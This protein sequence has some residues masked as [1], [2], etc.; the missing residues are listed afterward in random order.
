MTV[1]AHAGHRDTHRLRSPRL[2]A[3]RF[4]TRFQTACFESLL[5]GIL[6]LLTAG[7]A[8][9]GN[10][11]DKISAR[12]VV[13][14]ANEHAE[15]T[16]ELLFGD[17]KEKKKAST[18]RP[19]GRRELAGGGGG[20]MAA[21]AD[22]EPVRGVAA[23]ELLERIEDGINSGSWIPFRDRRSAGR[24]ILAEYEERSDDAPRPLVEESFRS[25]FHFDVMRGIEYRQDLPFGERG[26]RLD[27][28]GPITPGGPGL[29]LQ[30]KGHVV[31]HRFKLKAYGSTNEGGVTVDIE[32]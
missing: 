8:E 18:V 11:G 2:H 20:G 9:A 26:M 1:S 12:D 10:R 14:N 16:S 4:Q 30:L 32:F 6:L 25:R 13:E 31:E 19:V 27:V 28:Y 3:P 29:G 24:R 7:P 22:V 5:I 23:L 15:R 17:R 21:A